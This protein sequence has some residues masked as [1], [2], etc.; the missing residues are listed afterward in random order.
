MLVAGATIASGGGGT[1]ALLLGDFVL[2]YPEGFNFFFL[3]FF[4]FI[5]NLV[6]SSM[7]NTA[8]LGLVPSVPFF[9]LFKANVLFKSDDR[10]AFRACVFLAIAAATAAAALPSASLLI[11]IR[12][13]NLFQYIVQTAYLLLLGFTLSFCCRGIFVLLSLEALGFTTAPSSNVIFLYSSS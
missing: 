11:L 1:T 7:L 4:I 12:N 5:F 10:F 2:L 8:D 3:A 6:T 13:L 9:L